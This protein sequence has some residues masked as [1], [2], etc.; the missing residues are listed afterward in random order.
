[1]T[2]RCHNRAPFGKSFT[3]HGIDSQTG[4]RIAVE[5]RSDWFVDRCTLW[6]DRGFGPDTNQTF[7]E[8][9]GYDCGGC[10]WRNA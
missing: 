2:P 7:A 6:D 1:M 9:Q 8:W 5:V 10:R 4:G 3:R